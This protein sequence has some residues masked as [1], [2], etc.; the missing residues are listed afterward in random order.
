MGS[1]TDSSKVANCTDGAAVRLCHTGRAALTLVAQIRTRTEREREH[2]RN[3]GMAAKQELPQQSKELT[4]GVAAE[5]SHRQSSIGTHVAN[6]RT[7]YVVHRTEKE[8]E[9]ESRK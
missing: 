6:T 2:G 4:D 7:L 9:R 8:R 1:C 5:L 3:R